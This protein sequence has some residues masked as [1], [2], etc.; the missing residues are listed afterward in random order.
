V[1]RLELSEVYFG[2]T[3]YL[4]DMAQLTDALTLNKLKAMAE[5]LTFKDRVTGL[6]RPIAE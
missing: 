5:K 1:H 4:Q 3:R 2:D 6:Y